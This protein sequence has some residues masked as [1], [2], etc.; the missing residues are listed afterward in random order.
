MGFYERQL[1]GRPDGPGGFEIFTCQPYI[2]RSDKAGPAAS[3]NFGMIVPSS[4]AEISSA[5]DN[6]TY[7]ESLMQA[8]VRF[9]IRQNSTADATIDPSHIIFKF[10]GEDRYGNRMDLNGDEYSSFTKIV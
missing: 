10:S 1:H 5:P 6:V 7:D 2:D 8:T 9:T 4:E 3:Y